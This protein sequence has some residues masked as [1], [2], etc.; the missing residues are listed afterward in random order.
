MTTLTP[1]A[2]SDRSASWHSFS[3]APHRLFLWGGAL[4][5]VVS[6]ALWTWQQASLYSGAMAPLLWRV[7]YPSA[8]AFMMIYGVLG[9]YIFGFL[10]TTFPRWLDDQPVPRGVYLPA[11]VLMTAGAHGFW[12]GL[13]VSAGL[14]LAAVLAMVAAYA[15]AVTALARIALR[16]GADRSQQ[17]YMLGGLLLAMAGMAAMAV[18]IA[19]GS[20]TAYRAMRWI[21]LN[22]FLLLVVLPVVYRM[23]PFFTSTVTPD[24]TL[25]RGRYALPLLAL[26]II[27]R[28]VLGYAGLDGWRWLGDGLLLAVLLRE[29]VRWQFWRA[30][31]PPLL[32][33][34]YLAM[35]W[36]VA[37]FALGTGESLYVLATGGA[38]PFHNAALHALAVG[39]FGSLLLGISTRVSLGHS[40]GGL[41]TDRLLNGLFW[42][43]QIVPLARVLPE[44]AGAWVPSAAVQGYWSGVGWVL[45]FAV[46]FLRIGPVLMRPRSDGRP[47]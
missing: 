8:H 20:P 28:G 31:R 36:F 24:Y 37:S 22:G 38:A 29:L 30:R 9:F 41:A 43:Y 33:I 6:V 40:G 3:A 1:T 5:A 27:L 15:L 45:V 17:V 34:L 18:G 42:G 39:G 14:A 2:M 12:V 16:T 10:L 47:G 32:V 46:W 4:Y 26:G 11:W 35:A 44:V 19:T 25:R 7:P 23:V 21:G 13:F